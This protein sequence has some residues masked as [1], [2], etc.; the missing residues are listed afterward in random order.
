MSRSTKARS[1]ELFVIERAQEVRALLQ[2]IADRRCLLTVHADGSD[3]SV[4]TA[5]LGVPK[6]GHEFLADAGGDAAVNRQLVQA[7]TVLF[8]TQM[9]RVEVRFRTGPPVPTTVDGMPAWKLPLPSQVYYLQQREFFRLKVPVARP[10]HCD[11]VLP[12]DGSL[13]GRVLQVRA[14]DISVGGLG[15]T[16]APSQADDMVA[17]LRIDECRIALPDSGEVQA[18]LEVRHVQRGTDVRGV[19]RIQAGCEFVSPTNH[20]Q[21]MIQRYIMRVERERIS[22]ERGL[23]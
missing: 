20:L 6:S 16:L 2:R 22:R 10:V 3:V 18:R 17:G 23:A 12:A 9:D 21:A 13:P 11:L 4:L 8:L 7:R 15:L 14:A 5:I 19:L 1:D